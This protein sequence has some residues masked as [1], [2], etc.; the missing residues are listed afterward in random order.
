[1]CVCVRVGVV[2]VYAVYILTLVYLRSSEWACVLCIMFRWLLLCNCFGGGCHILFFTL[3]FLFSCSFWFFFPH[4]TCGT[5]G[6]S[7]AVA[8]PAPE[9]MDVGGCREMGG[10]AVPAF[11]GGGREDVKS[12]LMEVSGS[13]IRGGGAASCSNDGAGSCEFVGNCCGFPAYGGNGRGMEFKSFGRLAGYRS[14]SYREIG[15]IF[16]EISCTVN[17]FKSPSKSAAC[18]A[19]IRCVRPSD[20]ICSGCRATFCENRTS[21]LPTWLSM[22]GTPFGI[23]SCSLDC[24]SPPPCSTPTVL[25][26]ALSLNP[27]AK[28]SKA[29]LNGSMSGLNRLS[30]GAP[31]GPSSIPNLPPTPFP[32]A[33]TLEFATAAFAG[34]GTAVPRTSVT[35]VGGGGGSV[36]DVVG[37]VD[38]GAGTTVLIVFG[39][40]GGGTIASAC[41]LVAG[42]TTVVGG[43]PDTP[44]VGCKIFTLCPGFT[45]VLSDCGGICC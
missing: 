9:V 27:S 25:F 17:W 37:I 20:G 12:V 14:A 19:S 30:S 28:P 45:A 38:S 42:S 15:S 22:I 6:M 10:A 4:G 13:A 41:M 39:L 40:G 18:C 8:P 31:L 43:S 16:G 21:S 11:G 44:A 32:G 7:S 3:F 33:T 5:V 2:S 35:I 29:C 34:N 24:T 23:T 26:A 1:M 36:T